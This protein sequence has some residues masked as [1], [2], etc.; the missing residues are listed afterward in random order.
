MR[1]VTV[2]LAILA[3]IVGAGSPRAGWSMP[4]FARKYSMDC[5]A[6]HSTIPRLNEFGFQFRKAGFR[7]P[8]DIGK[9]TKNN[10]EDTMTARIQARY[11]YK[12]H[13]DAG[14]TTSSNQLTFH[15]VT[16][17]PLSACFGKYYASLMELSI[18]GEDFVEIENAYFRYARGNENAWFSGSGSSTPGRATAPR[19]GPTR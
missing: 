3:L 16:L 14:S 19:T 10:F 12:R 9:P 5:N 17:Y 2:R 18:L 11:D 6:C 8:S 15:E 1:R 13:D 7:L 4:N